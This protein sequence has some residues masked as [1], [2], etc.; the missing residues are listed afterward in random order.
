MN[1]YMLKCLSN[2]AQRHN[3]IKFVKI[4]AQKCINKYPEKYCPT[5]IIYKN[6]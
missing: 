4:I 6:V 5:L 1:C 3:K 2:I